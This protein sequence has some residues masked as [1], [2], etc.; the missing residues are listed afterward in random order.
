MY[1][2]R[3][4]CIGLIVLFLMS[5]SVAAEEKAD[6]DGLWGGVDV[7]FGHIQRSFAEI[8]EDDNNFFLGFKVGYTLNPDFLIG[9]ELSGWLF[10]SSDIN[11]PSRGEGLSQVLLITRYYPI[12]K[13]GFFVKTGGGYVSHWNNRPGEPRRRSGWGLNF[14]GGYDFSLN[15]YVSIT[16]FLTYSFGDAD[17]QEHGAL[18]AGIGF[19]WH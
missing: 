2:I 5:Y 17:E 15:S 16:P 8:E 9:V 10:E 7:G 18:T 11:D 6:R 12:R 3:S 19:T 4:I 14:G 13:S 1:F